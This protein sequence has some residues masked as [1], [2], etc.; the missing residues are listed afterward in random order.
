MTT[1]PASIRDVAERAGV[2][3]ATVSNVLGGRKPVNAALAE[4]VREAARSLGYEADR[5]ASLLRTGKARIIAVLVPDLDN[6]FF[7]SVVSAIE[8]S[9]RDQGY[10]IIVAS[11]NGSEATELSR[12][13]AML[14]WR[15]A[16]F[17][18]L[19]CSDDFPAR[20]RIEQA[21]IP[22]VI[23]D[24]ITRA[25][26]ADTVSVDNEDAGAIGARHLIENGHRNILV[27]ASVLDLGN[28]RERCEGVAAVLA[29]Q[30][31]AASRIE[32]GGDFETAS[33]RL[34]RW[35]DDNTPPTA[36]LALTNFTTLGVLAALAE[37]Q[38]A[39]PQSI[40]LIG[41]DDY[42]WMRA[43]ATPLTAISQPVQEIGEA[44]W[45]RLKARI[46]GDTSPPA[47]IQLKCTLKVRASTASLSPTDS[48]STGAV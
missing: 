36:I 29:Q 33:A 41:F 30:G 5:A 44:I 46:E 35:L 39:I 42:A 24:R 19:P 23:A 45:A 48:F 6:P 47:H 3:P 43:R 17:V 37:R 11:S 2:S 27:A 22:Y 1:K 20:S 25:P 38:I 9:L 14:A 7:T 12:L 4:R 32:T 21:K 15:P 10:E 31:L 26:T 40:S 18:V 13:S 34:S 16:G 8:T 28:I